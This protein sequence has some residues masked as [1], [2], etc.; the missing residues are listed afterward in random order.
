MIRYFGLDP[1]KNWTK[2]QLIQYDN[3]FM[4]EQDARG[5]VALA[6]KEAKKEGE[7]IGETKG[8]MKRV[9]KVIKKCRRKNM[10]IEDITDIVELSIEEVKKIIEQLERES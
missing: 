6:E 8:D 5:R 10:D 1:S 2:E 7:K 4:A 9:I 3:A